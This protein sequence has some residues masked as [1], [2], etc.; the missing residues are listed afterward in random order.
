MINPLNP[1]RVEQ[2]LKAYLDARFTAA[3]VTVP[4]VLGEAS[5]TMAAPSVIT[6]T[7]L[8]AME[9]SAPS[10]AVVA[11]DIAA[12]APGVYGDKLA[13]Q[14]VVVTPLAIPGITLAHHNALF[15]ALGA[16]FP[17]R[18]GT[19]ASQQDKDDWA[20][21]DAALSAAMVTAAGHQVHGWFV[22]AG[23][24]AKTKDRVEQILV[25]RPGLYHPDVV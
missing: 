19:A 25:L 5:V 13:I 21:L 8:T 24:Q 14:L 9:V 15:D 16:C 20:V 11:T 7:S 12:D 23:R 4:K 22:L 3:S 10:V 1:S 18:P 2:G 17:A 6:G